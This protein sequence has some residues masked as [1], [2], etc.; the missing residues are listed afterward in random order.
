MK[1]NYAYCKMANTT[2]TRPIKAGRVIDNIQN[3]KNLISTKDEC[4]GLDGEL[5]EWEESS[6]LGLAAGLHALLVLGKT[7]ADG[8]GLLNTEVERGVPTWEKCR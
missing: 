2:G 8:T 1:L 7:A 4:L 6:L 3:K 5:P